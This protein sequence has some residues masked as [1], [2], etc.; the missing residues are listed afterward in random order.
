MKIR[1]GWTCVLMSCSFALWGQ[2]ARNQ[3]QAP[4]PATV[5][6]SGTAN[7]VPLWTGASTLGNSK[8]FQTGGRIG[9]NTTTPTVQ[10]D[11]N[12]RMNVS[13][14]Y[15]IGGIDVL[16]I[17]GGND[18]TA[19]GNSA[20]LLVTGDDNTAV[21]F[22]ALRASKDAF[23]NTAVG[24]AALSDNSSGSGNTAVG[25]SALVQSSLGSNNTALGNLAGSAITGGDNVMIQNEGTASD[26]GV[27]RIGTAGSQ[28]SF[29]AAGIS[30]VTTGLNNAV[31]VVIDSN[32]QLGTISSSRRF[33]EDIHDMGEASDGLMRLR[34]VTFRYQQAF[35]D[36]SKPV[37]YGLIAEEVAEVYPDLV[38]HSAD[39]QVQT[40]K[41][42]VLD[43][44]LLNE[45]KKQR[46]QI[47]SLEERLAKMEA[48]MAAQK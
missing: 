9:V 23:F 48:A 16:S 26:N 35:A 44:M 43:S 6:G 30:G 38:A 36:G 34:P 42:Q 39:G 47:R 25:A 10:L 5:T 33:K 24:S 22:W 41:Y 3:A 1:Y 46:E 19:V 15:R 29:F 21:G 7:F 17:S 40:V 8:L 31:P 20:L 28:T 12:G 2:E 37:Q 13:K 45:V 11:V 4:P 18:D 14:T 27:I 32:G